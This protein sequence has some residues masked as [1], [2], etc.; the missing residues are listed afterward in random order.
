MELS[1][2]PKSGKTNKSG[3][4]HELLL[5]DRNWIATFGQPA[6]DGTPGSLVKITTAHTLKTASVLGLPSGTTVGWHKVYVSEDTLKAILNANESRDASGY[7]VEVEFFVPGD[8][9][10]TEE[11]FLAASNKDIVAL[12]TDPNDVLTPNYFVQLGNQ[13]HSLQIKASFDSSVGNDATK[14]RKGMAKGTIL[15]KFFYR[16]GSAPTIFAPAP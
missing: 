7:A 11:F 12:L 13:N 16:P 14:G 4:T 2:L 8:E 6:N 15:N 10:E 3:Y 1:N 5:I 9:V